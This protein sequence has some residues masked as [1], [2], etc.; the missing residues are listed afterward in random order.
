MPSNSST[1]ASVPEQS[2]CSH[3][4]LGSTRQPQNS[5]LRYFADITPE[6]ALAYSTGNTY[7][8][9]AGMRN[10]LDDIA[11]LIYLYISFTLV[12]K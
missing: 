6:K 7:L 1:V 12:Y 3:L 2:L 10:F 5:H 8:Y 9:G 4:S 11:Q